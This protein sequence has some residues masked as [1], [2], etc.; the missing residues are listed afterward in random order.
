MNFGTKSSITGINFLIPTVFLIIGLVL[1]KM[2]LVPDMVELNNGEMKAVTQNSGFLYASLFFLFASVIWFL[3][4]FGII[5]SAI[6]YG[7]MAV[8]AI[9]GVFLI[10]ADYTNIK[11]TVDFNSAFEERDLEI[12][13]RLDDI[14]Q[15]QLAF[16]EMNGTY[17]NS[18]DELISFVKNGKKMKI[19]KKGSI[20]ERKITVEE[21]DYL[22]GDDRPIDKLMTEIE[23]AAI[24]KSPLAGP[25]LAGFKRD[26]NYVPVMDAIFLDEKRLSSRSKIGGKIKFHP[27]SMRYVPFTQNLVVMQTD[28]IVRGEVSYPTL[29]IEMAHPLSHEL[30]DSVFYSIGALDDN[31][32]RESWK[33]K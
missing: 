28:S 1:L 6:G 32:L 17:T 24:S 11:K 14:K 4:L 3:Y 21:R 20:P 25:D 22:Y 5:K 23:A 26:T 2:A 33:E 13:T 7:V 31:N 16:K 12:K 10:Y 15:A 30:E 8:L 29:Y 9:C 27:D 19:L 18:M